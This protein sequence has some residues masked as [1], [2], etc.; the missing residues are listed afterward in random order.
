MSLA[1]G[2]ASLAAMA[3]AVVLAVAAGLA[4]DLPASA[5]SLLATGLGSSLLATVAVVA[6]WP[7]RPRARGLFG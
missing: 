2:A 7:L 4:R 3:Y 5:P 6:F 1:A